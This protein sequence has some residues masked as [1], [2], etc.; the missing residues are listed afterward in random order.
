MTNYPVYCYGEGCTNLAEFKIAARWSHGASSELKTYALACNRCLAKLFWESRRRQ[1][2]ARMLPG[3]LGEEPG[4]YLPVG[5]WGDREMV[6]AV[7][8]EADLIEQ[9][10]SAS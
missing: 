8:R 1:K 9:Q 6:R 10:A 3:E 4:I 5:G 7:E 2:L